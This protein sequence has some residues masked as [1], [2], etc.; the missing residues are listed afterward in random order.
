MS[1][2]GRCRDGEQYKRVLK[3]DDSPKPDWTERVLDGA[4]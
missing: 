1:I 3:P 4:L 2:G